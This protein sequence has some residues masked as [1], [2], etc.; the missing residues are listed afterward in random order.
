MVADEIVPKLE[1]ENSLLQKNNAKLTAQLE[2][3]E[4]RLDE[5]RKARHEAETQTEERIQEVQNT[6]S[7]VLAEKQDNWDARERSLEE[8]VE[9]QERLMKELKAS[10]EVNQRLERGEGGEDAI[11]VGASTAELDMVSADLER[12]SVRLAEVEARNEQLRLE[13]AQSATQHSITRN[14]IAVEDDPA[15]LR[16]RSENSSLL[17]KID[18]ARFERETGKRE[19]DAAT[20]SLRKEIAALKEDGVALRAKLQRWS[21]YPDMKRELE[22]LKTIEFSTGDDDF[23]DGEGQASGGYSGTNTPTGRGSVQNLEQLL[24]T[25]N[26]KINNELT[27][28]RVSHQDLTARLEALQDELSSTN[29]ELE[30]SRTLAATLENDLAKVQDDTIS[31]HPAMSV[32]GTYKSR[33]P[34]MSY[35]ASRRGRLSPTSSIISGMDPTPSSP[36]STLEGLRAGEPMGGG[37]GILPMI[38]AQRDRFK[39]RITELDAELSKAYQTISSLR[40][41]VAA[42]Q[43]D[44]LNLYEK[45]RFVSTYNKAPPNT[46]SNTYNGNS[47]PSTINIGGGPTSPLDRYKSAYDAKISPFAAFRGKESAR[48]L[49]RM[50]LPERAMLQVTKLV[51]ANR[52]SRNVFALYFFGLH[53]VFILMLFSSGGSASGSTNYA[54]GAAGEAVGGLAAAGAGGAA[55]RSDPN[56]DHGGLPGG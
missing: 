27:V 9:N 48:A 53:L 46:T 24:L 50:S 26:K 36:M 52:T 25:R 6:W 5:E 40:S 41:E 10:Y 30:K 47:N 2:E 12:V 22:I 44:N 28:L 21:D 39:K 33:Y 51:L 35:A 45:S 18:A 17:R 37:S 54:G 16:L 32:A 3:A 42:L 19:V 13:L 1:S 55:L 56:A 14:T 38:T 4:R 11:A 29:M 20:R 43:K 23:N 15:F 8:R 31:H 34:S 49:K 7:A